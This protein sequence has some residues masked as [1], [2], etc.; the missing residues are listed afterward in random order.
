MSFTSSDPETN[1]LIRGLPADALTPAEL[2]AAPTTQPITGG[3]WNDAGV[4]MAQNALLSAAIATAT[5]AAALV[6]QN[7]LV[8]SAINHVA[9]TYIR[10]P[11][12]WITADKTAW[13]VY[14]SRSGAAASSGCL[15]T[16]R[17][18][19]LALHT[20]IQVGDTF[21]F[22]TNANAVITRTIESLATVSGDLQ[23]GKFDSALP[24]TITP[25]KVLPA[26]FASYLTFGVNLPVLSADQESKLLVRDWTSYAAPVASHATSVAAARLPLTEPILSG[27]AGVPN[28]LLIDGEL[29]LLGNHESTTTFPVVSALLSATNSALTT[30]G[31]GYQLTQFDLVDYTPAAAQNA[32]GH[33]HAIAAIPGLL[34]ALQSQI[35]GELSQ[36]AAPTAA[37]DRAEG[38]A[39]AMTGSF[40]YTVSFITADGETEAYRDAQAITVTAKRV[41]LSAIPIGPTGVT[42]RRLWRGD[43]AG[44][45]YKQLALINDN[46]TTTYEDNAAFG[47]LTVLE[48]R[49]NRTGGFIAVNNEARFVADPS[50]TGVGAGQ[51]RTSSGENLSL[52]HI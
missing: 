22:L 8:L 2:Q 19:A 27:D 39:G 23:V 17:H 36:I 35:A 16:P 3:I 34:A 42:G 12:C 45:E 52:I 51:S 49:Y 30:L 5:D 28:F 46:T 25:C 38:S 11:S 40:Y 14:N 41:L 6:S 9:A 7:K 37:P 26:N 43:N 4:I 18:I 29:V 47:S 48:T 32:I 20:G 10:N 24:N 13:P 15:I 1:S 21:R 44:Y 31:G 33:T 50:F